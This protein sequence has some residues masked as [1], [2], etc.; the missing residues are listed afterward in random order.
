MSSKRKSLWFSSV[1]FLPHGY[2]VLVCIEKKILASLFRLPSSIDFYITLLKIYLSNSKKIFIL[3]LKIFIKKIV[4]VSSC[5]I[6]PIIIYYY[7]TRSLPILSLG[8][9]GH[10]NGEL[11]KDLE[12]QLPIYDDWHNPEYDDVSMIFF[13]TKILGWRH[14]IFWGVGC[15]PL[16]QTLKAVGFQHSWCTHL[17]AP[18]VLSC[19][20]IGGRLPNA[21]P[22]PP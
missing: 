16:T 9:A 21:L 11:W 12:K 15:L 7:S 6:W 2:S 17:S 14:C 13:S 18:L 3:P 19:G 4:L 22:Y 5:S 20:G 1:Q 10:C 8:P